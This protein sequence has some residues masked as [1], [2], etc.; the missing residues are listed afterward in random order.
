MSS[1][2]TNFTKPTEFIHMLETLNQQMPPILDDFIKYYVFYNKNPD[3][4][5]YQQMFENIKNNLNNLNSQL[6]MLTNTVQSKS[7][8]LNATFFNLNE[9]IVN[10]KEKN[11]SLKQKL[12]IVEQKNNS[13]TEM[14]TNYNQLYDIG[15][16]KNWGLFFSIILSCVALSVVFKK[17]NEIIQ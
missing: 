10:A 2:N 13:A 15:Y 9:L 17:Q 4:A 11:S 12:G 5:E 8:E 14:I 16:V 1:L 6:F 3:Y 7:Q